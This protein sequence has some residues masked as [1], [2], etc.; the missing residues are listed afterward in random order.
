MKGFQLVLKGIHIMQRKLGF[1]KPVETRQHIRRPTSRPPIPV[2][3]ELE[4]PVPGSY[5]TGWPD[6]PFSHQENTPLFRDLAEVN[7]TTHITSPPG[8]Y[9]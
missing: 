8:S 2:I 4:P 7:Q 6:C 1:P 5:L 9:A 3:Q